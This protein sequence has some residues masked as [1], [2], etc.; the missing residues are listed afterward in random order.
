MKAQDP[1]APEALDYS[2]GPYAVTEQTDIFS[3]GV[4]ML[5]ALTGR[6]APRGGS[7]G[8]GELRVGK[9]GLGTAGYQA[10]VSEEMREIVNRMLATNPA[11]RPTAS[12]L[13]ELSS[14]DA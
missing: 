10:A 5:E 3:L 8:Y 6:P 1:S 11:D 9:I 2:S 12:Q 4:V 14:G 7:S 13:L